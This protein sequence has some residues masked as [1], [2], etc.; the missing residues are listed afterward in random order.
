MMNLVLMKMKKWKLVIQILMEQNDQHRPFQV[1]PSAQQ[2]LV[3]IFK[4]TIIW[5]TNF[6]MKI[7]FF[8]KH[9]I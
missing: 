4:I 7:L 6:G 8:I 2:I 1:L 5:N 9:L 3:S